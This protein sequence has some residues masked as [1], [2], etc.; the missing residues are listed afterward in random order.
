MEKW[1]EFSKAV[2][3]GRLKL[4]DSELAR[5]N[6]ADARFKLAKNFEK[7]TAKNITDRTLNGYSAAFG[8][9]LAYTAAEQVG[10]LCSK[11]IVKWGIEDQVL[12]SN[13]RPLMNNIFEDMEEHLIK[14][15]AQNN[16][17]DFIERKNNNVR[18]AATA[19]RIMV[20]HGTFS[21]HGGK[22]LTK[23]QCAVY[24]TLKTKILKEADRVFFEWLQNKIEAS[25]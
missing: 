21:P 1:K 14:K 11:E 17:T 22:A 18:I 13:L 3:N 8:V 2:K 16:F 6:R 5:A 23:K 7:I 9:F 10:K 25:R 24:D 20:A 15:R 4:T 12:A 19:I